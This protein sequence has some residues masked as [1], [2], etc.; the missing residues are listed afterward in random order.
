VEEEKSCDA[1]VLERL[2]RQA[3]AY[4]EG[5]LKSIEFLVLKPQCTP[6]L[7]TGAGNAMRLEERMKAILDAKKGKNDSRKLRGLFVV[8]AAL[9]L[10]LAPAWVGD[11][12]GVGEPEAAKQQGENLQIHREELRLQKELREIESKHIQVQMQIEELVQERERRRV[13]EEIERLEAQGLKEEAEVLR[14]KVARA[15]REAAFN[16]QQH[17]LELEYSQKREALE[18][19]LQE[20]ALQREELLL[21]GDPKQADALLKRAQE[22]ELQLRQLQLEVLRNDL[23]RSR[24]LLGLSKQELE[25]LSK[26]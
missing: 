15:E 14:Q 19:Q 4:A 23:E 11:S 18:F 3:R 21:K 9:T 24:E 13:R 26:P 20:L 5:L 2:P 1:L 25:S 22:L 8:P 12:V 10:L 7:A 6:A 17:R 16:R